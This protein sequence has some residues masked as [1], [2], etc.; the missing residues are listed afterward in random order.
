[1]TWNF[2][3]KG[4]APAVAADIEKQLAGD[5]CNEP[6]E[7]VRQAAGALIGAALAAQDADTDVTV[8]AS[9]SQST[10]YTTNAISNGLSISVQ[11][12]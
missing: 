7:T 5:K 10:N 2:S 11:P 4:K 12:S 1:M 6:E 8:S 9:G 3:G